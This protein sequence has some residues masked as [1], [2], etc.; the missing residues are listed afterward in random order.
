MPELHKIYCADSEVNVELSERAKIIP[1]K[2][3][4]AMFVPLRKPGKGVSRWL[5]AADCAGP[6]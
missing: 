4:W 1:R 6:C 2:E 5:D 3:D